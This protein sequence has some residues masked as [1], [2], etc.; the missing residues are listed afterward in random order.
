MPFQDLKQ[1]FRRNVVGKVSNNSKWP[2]KWRI[3]IQKAL[4]ND[5]V[6]Q[7]RICF[8]QVLN[9]FI[10]HFH[11]LKFNPWNLHKVFSQC[12]TTRTYLQQLAERTGAQFRNDPA[13]YLFIFEKVLPERFFLGC[14][15]LQNY[16]QPGEELKKIPVPGTGMIFTVYNL[17]IFCW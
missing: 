5:P 9:L 11:C 3:N 17:I 13:T 15:S 2:G 8:E 12:T 16:M 6:L 1:Y 14:T 10:I 4:M 7:H